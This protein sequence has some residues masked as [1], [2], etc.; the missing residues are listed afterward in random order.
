MHQILLSLALTIGFANP[1]FAGPGGAYGNGPCKKDAETL[2]PGIKPGDG[3]LAKCLKENKDK[4]SP[5]CLAQH[6][7]MKEAMSEMKEACHDDVQKLCADVPPGKGRI[8]KCLKRQN[9]QLSEA[10]KTEMKEKKE[11]FKKMK[12]Q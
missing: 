11:A 1:S 2:C 6:E 5:D 7:K 10:C 12:R 8:M 3:G 9:D 4:L